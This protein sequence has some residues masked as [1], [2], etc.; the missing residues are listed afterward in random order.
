MVDP[1]DADLVSQLSRISQELQNLKAKRASRIG[2]NNKATAQ[3]DQTDPQGDASAS[4][5]SDGKPTEAQSGN[6]E[7]TPSSDSTKREHQRAPWPGMAKVYIREAHNLRV[8]SVE[9]G[10]LSRGGIS[11]L[12]P[13]YI[14]EGSEVL[15]EKPIEGGFFRVMVTV[16]NVRVQNGGKHRIGAQFLGVPMKPGEMPA[17]FDATKAA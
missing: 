16:M 15:F 6:E 13:Q 2:V 4:G 7:Q 5:Q 8:L 12:S 17:A 14:Y 10:D 3:A 1:E 11:F 9:T